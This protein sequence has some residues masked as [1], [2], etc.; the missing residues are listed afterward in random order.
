VILKFFRGI[1]T[2]EI[3]DYLRLE[4]AEE[5]VELLM[6]SSLLYVGEGVHDGATRRYW[7]YPTSSGVAWVSFS[8]DSGSL[9]TKT[10][11]DVPASIRAATASLEAHPIR[12]VERSS[13]PPPDRS[14]VPRPIWVPDAQIPALSYFPMYEDT[15]SIHRA[16]TAFSA[17]LERTDV[18]YWMQYFCVKLT[19]GRY[20]LLQAPETSSGQ[21]S[22]ELEVEDSHQD[23][24]M[25]YVHR[26]D[27]HEIL[28]VLGRECELP[29]KDCQ[30][31]WR[32]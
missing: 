31:H 10:A 6:L 12:K 16:A 2:Q 26:G 5:T 30:Y 8:P 19:S 3:L 13:R 4:E 32:D 25:G 1:S 27:L 9:G 7:S 18:G 29:L 22:I 11:E 21:I 17:E 23:Y 24:P 20:A 28:G 15:V 14:P